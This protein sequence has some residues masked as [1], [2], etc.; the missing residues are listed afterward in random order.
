MQIVFNPTLIKPIAI[1][2]FIAIGY[3]TYLC[4]LSV[5]FVFVMG[6]K[7]SFLDYFY[8][9]LPTMPFLA[10]FL[11]SKLLSKIS[12]SKSFFVLLSIFLIMICVT[13]FEFFWVLAGFHPMIGG[14]Y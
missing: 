13:Y 11:S 7:R 10:V 2:F 1:N 9:V 5:L 14:S 4:L 8:L 12:R 6:E 3:L